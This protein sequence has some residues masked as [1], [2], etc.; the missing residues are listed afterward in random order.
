MVKS[1]A[2]YTL[3]SQISMYL[4]MYYKKLCFSWVF[5]AAAI[6][7]NPSLLP[8]K[9]PERIRIS[10]RNRF[11]THTH[12]IRTMQQ[13]KKKKCKQIPTKHM[14]AAGRIKPYQPSAARAV[15]QSAQ[16]W[17]VYVSVQPAI[18]FCSGR[19]YT[20]QT[21]RTKTW[22]RVAGFYTTC[23]LRANEYRRA[24]RTWPL[25]KK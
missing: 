1:A 3:R 20:H 12:T 6:I 23:T 16:L 19:A 15:H 24:G 2:Q 13:Q 9:T 8:A 11:D 4:S 22:A 21:N 7:A 18:A 5:T 25:Q 14:F 10:Y 17:C